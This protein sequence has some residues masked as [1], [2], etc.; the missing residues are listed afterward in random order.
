MLVEIQ[1][2]FG[3][4]SPDGSQ[5]S[6]QR[7][8][9]LRFSERLKEACEAYAECPPLNRGLYVWIAEKFAA[10]G[11]KL[12]NEGIRRWF[13]GMTYPR[14]EYM[15]ILAQIVEVDEEWLAFGKGVSLTDDLTRFNYSDIPPQTQ[16]LAAVIRMHGG[17]VAFPKNDDKKRRLIDF[18]AII[19]GAHYHVKVAD[20]RREEDG[21][22]VFKVP[23]ESRDQ[24]VV[25]VVLA[26]DNQFEFW[27]ILPDAFPETPFGKGD[28]DL[29]IP[30]D[31]QDAL[32]RRISTFAER[33]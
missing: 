31:H 26:D 1:E 6:K 24:F 9:L 10:K 3:M 11:H 21:T 33:P 16:L 7:N 32:L 28:V 27:E 14:P 12:S 13:A 17:N 30:A 18:Y 22:L 19:G 20:G 25:G 15:R 29:R 5:P 4:S 2:D 23:T 8:T